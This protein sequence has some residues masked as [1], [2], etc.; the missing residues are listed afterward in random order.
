MYW[1]SEL[2][3]QEVIRLLAE[4]RRDAETNR[5]LKEARAGARGRFSLLHRLRVR[6]LR[7]PALAA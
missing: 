7:R 4:R 2:A 1:D 6:L 5:R 3:Y